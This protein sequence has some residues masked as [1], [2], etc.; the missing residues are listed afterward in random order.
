MKKVLS[1]FL[2]ILMLLSIT[3]GIDL[4]AYA[5]TLS[6]SCG[7]NVTWSLDT[8][9]G[10]LT[11]SGKGNMGDYYYSDFPWYEQRT[12][13]KTID[14]K[15]G[16]TSIASGAFWGCKNLTD[17]TI[18]NSV[19]SI[20][21]L[22]F[23]GC[24]SLTSV[25]IPNSVTEIAFN[26]F[27]NNENLFLNCYYNS[28]AKKF[29]DENGIKCKFISNDG[30]EK[31]NAY[32]TKSITFSYRKEKAWFLF[33][34]D[35]SGPYYIPYNVGDYILDSNM[36]HVETIN[37]D[38]YSDEDADYI[39]LY[40]YQ[41]EKGETYY[42]V[43]DSYNYSSESYEFPLTWD[44][45]IRLKHDHINSNGKC[46]ICGR[47]EFVYT[48]LD[49]GTAEITRYYDYGELSDLIIPSTVDGYT[50][51][52]IGAKAFSF[53]KSLTSVTIPN[54]VTHIGPYAFNDCDI[55][56]VTIPNSVTNI[57]WYAFN[58]C[59]S[60]TDV[61]YT[62]TKNEWNK[63]FIVDFDNGN[64]DLTESTIHCIDG[65]ICRHEFDDGKVT[66]VSTCTNS[67]TITYTCTICGETKTETI[68]KTAHTYKTAT[69]KATTKK[70]GTV[71]KKCSVCGT[72]TK[73]TICAIKTVSL[74]ATSYTY[75]GKA[76][77]PSVTVK[78][79]KGKKIAASNYTVKYTN[80]KNVGTATV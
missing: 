68:A 6:G 51:T 3:A 69:T 27:E 67:G 24:Y 17:V 8:D 72:T 41:L 64:E 22:A 28:Y 66:K 12:E 63:I 76:K 18:P 15:S 48:I 58:N 47:T 54:S 23:R 46:I 49:D 80:N 56:S 26:A 9:T 21:S 25:T 30:I 78:D 36:N 33:T 40:C 13:V 62:G 50:I 73:S 39:G 79:S 70:N 35:E 11:I 45:S 52:S 1:V 59:D 29:A 32:E 31:I 55:K 60:L 77:K 5:Q 16:V 65:I 57:Q 2:S 44:F 7:D 61:Y 34:P 4:S 20:R 74:S 43:S 37:F 75:N 71:T 38:F 42:I 10:T 53:C 14:I 19:T